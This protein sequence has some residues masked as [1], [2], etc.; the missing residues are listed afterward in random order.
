MRDF[1]QYLLGISDSELQTISWQEIV[2]RLMDLRDSNPATAAG[3]S[4]RHRR[5]LGSQ[6]KERLDAHDIANRLMRKQNYLIALF[7]K[8]I[9]DLTLPIPFLQNR[10]LFSRTLE[11]NISLCVMDYV[12][13]NEGQVKK[14]FLKDSN[15]QI[16]SQGL[17]RR[18][19][20]AGFINIFVAPFMVTYFLMLYFFRNFTEYQKN[21]ARIGSR[22]YS[23]L[24]EWKF[25]E[26][27]ELWHLF[28]R[29]INMSHPFASRYVDQFPKDKTIQ[30]CRFIAFV[31]GA[32]AAVLALGALF[33][34]EMFLN[35]EI[36]P[37]RT[38]LFYLTIFGAIWAAT[39][40][41]LPDDNVVFDPE[42]ALSEVI[43]FTRYSPAH[44][45]G[46][47]HSDDVR[48]EFTQLYQMELVTFLEEILS[49]VYTPFVLWFSL[50]NCSERLIDFFREFTVHVDGLGYVCSFAVFDF[51]KNPN[52]VQPKDDHAPDE[53]GRPATIRQDYY[54]TKDN[55]LEASYWGFMND[56]ALGIPPY[57]PQS[58]RHRYRPP[59]SFPGP[60]SPSLMAG[61]NPILAAAVRPEPLDKSRIAGSVLGRG[62]S[63]TSKPPA[64]DHALHEEPPTSLLLDHHRQP[65]GTLNR[66]SAS[67]AARSR[68]R[69][70]RRR[71]TLTRT[72]GAEDEDEL[73]DDATSLGESWKMQRAAALDDEITGDSQTRGNSAASD[74]G[75]KPSVLGIIK[76]FQ[77]DRTHGRA[78]AG[79]I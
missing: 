63:Q 70:S 69:S 49:M 14:A 54:S 29:R 46:H 76:Q 9:L 79:I 11:W 8:E 64:A 66:T 57:T 3:V 22:Q 53:Q 32:L 7:N 50:P 12:F 72:I 62:T 2:G 77:L 73:H 59:P 41:T 35:F 36:T 15:R 58:M 20:I 65:S 31:S 25:R 18:F 68:N 26:F 1:Y 21:P 5:F 24:A 52:L 39:R 13:N 51:K 33:D 4:A 40:N 55:K 71:S 74:V 75:D 16:L 17:R 78:N 28:K 19:L 44:W 38:V 43:A 23:P 48:K 10:Q 42:Q 27:N 60:M 67:G 6:S 56:Y 34:T 37:N 30:I 47:Y 45:E 61:G